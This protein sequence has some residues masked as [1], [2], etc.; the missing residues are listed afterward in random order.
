L[1]LLIAERWPDALCPTACLFGR[2]RNDIEQVSSRSRFKTIVAQGR[3]LWTCELTFAKGSGV[4]LSELRWY[5]EGLQGKRGTVML[6]DWNVDFPTGT[7]SI[8]GTSAVIPLH[9]SNGASTFTWSG[10]KTWTAPGSFSV[11]QYS[12][13]GTFNIYVKGLL[14]NQRV[15]ARG[16]YIQVG[17]RLYLVDD[18]AISTPS[19]HA[20]VTLMTPLI[21]QANSGSEIR[22]YRAACEMSLANQEWGIRGQGGNPYREVTLSFIET[23]EDA[24]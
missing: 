10:S 5:I 24:V 2:S 12:A 7:G 19:G 20:T 14:P 1:T 16:D 11:Y 9:W 3:P 22:L 4:D 23:V 6:W 8:G 15:L 18:D 13:V 17:K 21:S